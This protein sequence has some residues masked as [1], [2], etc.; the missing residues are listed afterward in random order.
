MAFMDFADFTNCE[1]FTI[2]SFLPYNVNKIHKSLILMEH[3]TTVHRIFG[4]ALVIIMYP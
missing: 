2:E 1:C 3:G 4:S